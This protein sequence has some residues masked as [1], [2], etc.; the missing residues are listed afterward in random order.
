MIGISAFRAG[1]GNPCKM[2]QPYFFE[3]LRPH[4]QALVVRKVV[5]Q[6][7]K[8]DAFLDGSCGKFRSIVG[9]AGHQL[10]E[11][12]PVLHHHDHRIVQ[13]DHELVQ[14]LKDAGRAKAN[15]DPRTLGLRDIFTNVLQPLLH[16]AFVGPDHA[17]HVGPALE[18]SVVQQRDGSIEFSR[19]D[20]RPEILHDHRVLTDHPAQFEIVLGTHGPGAFRRCAALGRVATHAKRIPRVTPEQLFHV[21]ILD[22]GLEMGNAIRYFSS[23]GG[24]QTF[25]VRLANKRLNTWHNR[26][27]LY[28]EV[29]SSD[30]VYRMC[31]I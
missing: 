10:F 7:E 17:V 1:A 15:T 20:R 2:G 13:A 19:L 31:V 8:V 27:P 14:R 12:V 5:G 6:K 23:Q 9:R 4:K 3:K 11:Q 24:M 16:V 29:F 18:A 25:F 28:A 26:D 22:Q 30:L 21:L